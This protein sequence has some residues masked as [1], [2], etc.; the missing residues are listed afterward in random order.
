M[1]HHTATCSM[2][3]R[4]VATSPCCSTTSSVLVALGLLEERRR[5]PARSSPS[6]TSADGPEFG[7]W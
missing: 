5:P 7:D 1:S 2:T 4:R 3:L 6:P